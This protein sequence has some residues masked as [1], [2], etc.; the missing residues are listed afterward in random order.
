M[1]VMVLVMM[2]AVSN[3]YGWFEHD[4]AVDALSH[5]QVDKASQL[6]TLAL[7]DDPLNQTTV[8]DAAVIAYKS[9]DYQTAHDYFDYLARAAT[10]DTLKMQSRFNLGNT[11]VRLKQLEQAIESYRTVLQD[12]PSHEMA[13]HNLEKV[14]EMLKQ[15]QEQ[16]QEEQQ[17]KE[18]Q[19]PESSD[20]KS[21]S[22]SKSDDSSSSQQERQEN[23]KQ[24][25]Q[26]GQKPQQQDQSGNAQ[27]QQSGND[28][29]SSAEGSQEQSGSN[30]SGKEKQQSGSRNRRRDR[31]AEQSDKHGS[32]DTS[33]KR[34][35][36]AQ[37]DGS[38][39]EADTPSGEQKAQQ[40][41]SGGSGTSAQE[42]AGAHRSAGLEKLDK[43]S[44]LI[45]QDHA[46]SDAGLNKQ[47]MR[48]MVGNQE[49]KNNDV[50]Q[51]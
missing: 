30:G 44:A 27:E 22:E 23:N 41:L 48:V 16:Q 34:D 13:R 37:H 42:G 3:V 38:K 5:G 19:S 49:R 45:V 21:K 39:K 33:A 18:K 2:V 47:L 25:Q 11:Q 28:Q 26:T 4:K 15:Q 17:Q 20:E 7:T 10:T 8:Y 1:N 6:I 31:R 24:Q 35:S 50:P 40:A 29:Q 43:P 46:E 9:G 12:D 51:W 36:S 14:Q 32:P